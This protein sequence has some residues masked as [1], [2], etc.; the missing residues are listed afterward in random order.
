[1]RKN[2]STWWVGMVLLLVVVAIC[3]ATGCGRQEN[4]RSSVQSKSST[5]LKEKI[6]Q[7]LDANPFLKEQGIKIEAQKEENGYVTLE[8]TEGNRR[9]RQGIVEG[10]DIQNISS[11]ELGL[12]SWGKAERETLALVKRVVARVEKLPGVK[13]VIVKAAINTLQ[14]Q[15]SDINHR[16]MELLAAKDYQ[17]ALQLYEKAAALGNASAQND[18]G[19]MLANGQGIEKNE[20]KAVEW[21]RKSAEQGYALAQCNLG[22]MYALGRGIPKDRHK[23][24]DFFCKSAEQGNANA[25][26]NI[27]LAYQEGLGT[28]KDIIQ[29]LAWYQKTA[30][31]G[32]VEG[33][34]AAAWLY[35]T[36]KVAK[37]RNAEKALEYAK[38]AVEQKPD[39]WNFNGTLAAA[40]AAN[41]QFEKAVE[42]QEQALRLLN[43]DPTMPQKE[44]ENEI[45]NAEKRI[46]LYKIHKPYIDDQ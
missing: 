28:Q 1:M 44:K 33:R 5:P 14:D 12:A 18:L 6:Q 29:A 27:G 21:Y 9:V 17:G 30:E 3:M 41:G 38:L 32:Y 37:F 36:S 10:L 15:A 31:Q 42:L 11:V 19:A 8:M 24:F 13:E 34:N 20:T 22:A 26:L 25:Q 45:S 23:A 35:A 39:V 7:E 2:E 16:A 46:Q 4:G 40:Y 43:A